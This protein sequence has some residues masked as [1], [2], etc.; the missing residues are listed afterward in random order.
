MNVEELLLGEPLEYTISE[1]AQRSG[2][3]EAYGLRIWAALGFPTPPPD[4]V[5][6]T[7]EDIRAMAEIHELLDHEYVD[8]E[9]VVQ[10]ARGVG[11]T[12]G[13]LASW[14]GEV[15]LQRLA[16]HLVEPGQPVT[17]D[18]VGQALA[19]SAELRPRFEHLLL[20]G[21]RRQLSAAGMRV[22]TST[23]AATADPA[24]GTALLA[25]GF[26]DI[27]SFTRLSRTLAG[28]QLA[29]LVEDF[30]TITA[31]IIAEL[32]GRVIKTLGDE[33]L[34]TAP[35]A[36]AGAEIALRIAERS[37]EEFPKVRVGIAFGEVIL[38]LG[39]VFGT[40]VNLAARLTSIAHPGTV[41]IDSALAQ[42]L[43]ARYDRV[44]LRSRPLQGL[45]KVR[46]WLL[47]RP[48]TRRREAS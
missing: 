26:A 27:V 36:A 34:F 11:Q 13:R 29:T 16:E 8:E 33:V 37:G 4:A 17:E 9:M 23:A 44:S 18:I 31:S 3:S 32:G 7:E 30:E 14:L 39:D 15:W 2:I 12:M 46:P 43:D 22:L 28:S 41:V 10:L 38:R 1:V 6:F 45:G 25:V 19:A 40:P 21:W 35:D 48:T 20:R 47:R 42:A 5:A 24:A